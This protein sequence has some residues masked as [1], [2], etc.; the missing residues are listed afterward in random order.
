MECHYKVLGV[1]KDA[2]LDDIKRAY[3]KLALKYHPDKNNGDSNMFKKI[4]QS[5]QILSDSTKRKD[6]D[7]RNFRF[8]DVLSN[9]VNLF[10]KMATDIKNSS[11]TN[12]VPVSTIINVKIALYD[13]YFAKIKKIVCKIKQSN[14]IVLKPFYI[15]LLNYKNKYV[16][17]KEGD[18]GGDLILNIRIDEQ[19]IKIDTIL[20]QNDLYIEKDIS[21][22]EYYYGCDFEFQHID[23][24]T[25]RC[26]KTFDDGIMTY[27]FKNMGLP[28]EYDSLLNRFNRGHLYVFFKIIYKP[29]NSISELNNPEFKMFM[30]NI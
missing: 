19:H 28:H 13:I 15:S 4:N 7:T 6:Y 11:N 27:C 12:T 20:N 24:T 17:P 22:Y 30:R 26:I 9:I 18:D 16:F 29:H 25:L 3:R 1:S 8:T 2:T 23:N 21:L 14:L 10:F 5:Y